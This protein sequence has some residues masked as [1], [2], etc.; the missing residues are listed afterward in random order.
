MMRLSELQETF[1]AVAM[2]STSADALTGVL[3]GP[4]DASRPRVQVY[5]DAYLARLRDVLLDDYPKLA[6]AVGEAFAALSVEYI[7]SYPSDRPSL[8]HF[9]RHVPTFLLKHPRSEQCPWLADLA[10]LEWARVEAFDAA[11]RQAMS[12]EDLHAIAGDGLAALRL[13]LV[14]SVHVLELAWPADA[15]W[16]ALDD[17]EASMPV[18]SG[19]TTLVVWRS[20]FSVRHRRCDVPEARAIARVSRAGAFAEVCEAWDEERT[21]IAA[22]AGRATTALCQW[23]VDGWI[24]SGVNG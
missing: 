18:S 4:A 14:P 22:A 2:G 8:R 11:D 23:V 15:I 24:A 19:P 3:G 13:K 12:V 21:D 7:R 9:G 10:R 6:G 5:V 20:G 16:Q 17:G 1:A